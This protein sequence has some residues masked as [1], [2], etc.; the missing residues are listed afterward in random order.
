MISPMS[1]RNQ[2]VEVNEKTM[3]EFDPKAAEDRLADLPSSNCGT[4]MNPFLQSLF[5]SSLEIADTIAGSLAEVF[6]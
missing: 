5:P 2:T 1:C 6:Q 3:T 4:S